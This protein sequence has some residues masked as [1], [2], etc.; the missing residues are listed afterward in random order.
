MV[1]LDSH[2]APTPAHWLH[3]RMTGRTVVP[4]SVSQRCNAISCND[5]CEVNFCKQVAPMQQGEVRKCSRLKHCIE[6]QLHG[7]EEMF[8][9]ACCLRPDVDGLSSAISEIDDD[10][11]RFHA[12]ERVRE[13]THWPC[14]PSLVLKLECHQ[15]IHLHLRKNVPLIACRPV[16]GG[17]SCK[18]KFSQQHLAQVRGENKTGSVSW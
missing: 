8:S 1:V 18:L 15:W 4:S 16:E 3:D 5:H 11:Q 14:S 7:K 12:A 6:C 13:A 2:P 17:P 9:F 10:M